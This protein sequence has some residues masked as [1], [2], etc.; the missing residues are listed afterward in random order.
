M[1]M[2]IKTDIVFGDSYYAEG[3]EQGVELINKLLK[4]HSLKIN[5]TFIEDYVDDVG[6]YAYAVDVEELE[7]D[8]LQPQRGH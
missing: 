5:Y 8:K 1:I 6:E 2:W 4:S 3:F 7:K